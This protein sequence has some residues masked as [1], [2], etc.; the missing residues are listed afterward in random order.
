MRRG[1]AILWWV[2]VVWRNLRWISWRS[3]WKSLG[4]WSEMGGLGSNNEFGCDVGIEFVVFVEADAVDAGSAVEDLKGDFAG[5]LGLAEDSHNSLDAFEN[6]ALGY[7]FEGDAARELEDT[8]SE[9]AV[10]EG[11]LYVCDECSPN[12][13]AKG[14][15]KIDS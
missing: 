2:I 6:L 1:L 9:A 8:A 14:Y 4:S 15:R 3:S 5:D 12:Q 7:C 13:L 10:T 11:F